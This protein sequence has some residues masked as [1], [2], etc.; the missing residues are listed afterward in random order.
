MDYDSELRFHN[1]A[2]RR[3]SDIAHDERVLDIGCGIGQTTR[4][5][6]RV[7]VTGSA[8]GVDTSVA[9]IARARELAAAEGL[10]NVQFLHA[11]AEVH[12]FP[13]ERFDVA[14]SRFGTMFFAD[15]VAAF[16]NI[17]R[18]LRPGSRLVMMVWQEHALNE[19]SVEIQRCLAPG[20]R[21]PGPAE[22]S[23]AFSLA[24]P[25]TV[26]RILATAGFVGTRFTNVHEPVYY[27][28]SVAAAFD[29][30]RGFSCTRNLLQQLDA[31]S[32]ERALERLRKALAERYKGRG[33]WFDSRA[34]IVTATRH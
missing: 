16:R 17:G 4:E 31:A 5:A 26:A 29:W 30:I 1:E 19:W 8:L 27:G 28:P 10:H 23:D 22:T 9:M 24:D 33:V 32:A 11:D 13:I 18:A 2:L 14:I 34:W 7:A 3:A 6:A 20:M 25:T 12:G 15:P 21:P